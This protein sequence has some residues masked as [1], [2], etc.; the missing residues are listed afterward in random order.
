MGGREETHVMFSAQSTAIKVTPGHY[1]QKAQS[2][3]LFMTQD[4]IS[5]RGGLGVNA[6][7]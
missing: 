1:K 3:S 2:D 7:E 5:I 6:I 4:T